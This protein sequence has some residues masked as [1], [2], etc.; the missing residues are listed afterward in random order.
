MTNDDV[1]HAL[2]LVELVGRV[3]S[4]EPLADYLALT[5]QACEHVG[6]NL[7]L[8]A[9]VVA[10]SERTDYPLQARIDEERD[11][12]LQPDDIGGMN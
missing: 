2:A 11:R 12:A 6:P 10:I 7:Y 3:G 1:L 5:G 8:A 9:M 4:P